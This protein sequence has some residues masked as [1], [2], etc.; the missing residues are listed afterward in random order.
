MTYDWPITERAE[1]S[2]AS[3]ASA[4]RAA[5]ATEWY[6]EDTDALGLGRPA[7]EAV[8]HRAPR[9][10]LGGEDVEG[11]VPRLARVDDQ[12]Q[13]VLMGQPDLGR[14]RRLL[15]WEGVDQE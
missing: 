10:P 11:V 1:I 14:E 3:R 5:E 13:P 7:G 4:A 8:E 9:H 2:P 12:R 6:L 15:R